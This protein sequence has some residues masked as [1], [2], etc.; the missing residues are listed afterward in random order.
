MGSKSGPEDHAQNEDSKSQGF[1]VL[2]FL[3]SGSFGFLWFP[4]VLLVFSLG[5]FGVLPFFA[6]VFL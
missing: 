5:S 4:L 3:L 2:W 6:S 1:G